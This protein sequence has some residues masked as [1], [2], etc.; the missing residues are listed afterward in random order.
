VRGSKDF[1]VDRLIGRIACMD[2]R[3]WLVPWFL[4]R[5][6]Q[7]HGGLAAAGRAGDGCRDVYPRSRELGGKHLSEL[8][9]FK[10]GGYAFG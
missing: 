5:A 7:R 1:S 8:T 9:I 4:P 2:I 10:G 3:A 6:G